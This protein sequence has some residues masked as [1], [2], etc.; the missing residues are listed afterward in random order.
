MTRLA[1]VILV[2]LLHLSGMRSLVRIS[3][4]IRS[5]KRTGKIAPL[6]CHYT[7]TSHSATPSASI[8]DVI[9]SLRGKRGMPGNISLIL[10]EKWKIY[11]AL[12]TGI[13]GFFS[14]TGEA[15]VLTF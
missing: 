12:S 11:P 2:I 15:A 1:R 4:E 3:S 9:Q 7:F 6:L 5:L 8:A 13:E 14:C 10:R